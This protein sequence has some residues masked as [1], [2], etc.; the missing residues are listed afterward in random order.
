[1]KTSFSS[2]EAQV[3]FREAQPFCLPHV[4]QTHPVRGIQYPVWPLQET[5]IIARSR[6]DAQFVLRG[7]VLCCG[8][9]R[10]NISEKRKSIEKL[11]TSR[12]LSAMMM[13]LWMSSL[14]SELTRWGFPLSQKLW[15]QWCCKSRHVNVNRGAVYIEIDGRTDGQIRICDQTDRQTDRLPHLTEESGSD[16]AEGIRLSNSLSSAL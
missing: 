12:Q 8:G 15:S 7:V 5:K 6:R 10:E 11:V 4:T 16:L 3:H 14:I 1:M 2:R 9:R 13:L